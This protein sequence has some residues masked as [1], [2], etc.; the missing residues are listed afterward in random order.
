MA[1]PRHEEVRARYHGHCGYC[2]VEEEASGGQLTVDHYRPR[3]AGGGDDLGNLV[4]ACFRCNLYKGDFYPADPN[5]LTTEL[6]ILHPLQDDI[7]TNIYLERST[8]R[9]VGVTD[10]GRFHI[11]M[12]QLNRPELVHYRRRR[13]ETELKNE[14]LRQLLVENKLQQRI[15]EDLAALIAELENEAY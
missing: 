15:I 3:A 6:R 2:G 10:T 14:L 1:H 11:S 7:E 8:G 12:L 4:Y 9:M 5:A 13:T